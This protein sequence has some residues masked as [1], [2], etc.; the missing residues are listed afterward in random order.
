MEEEKLLLT[1]VTTVPQECCLCIFTLLSC[2][3]SSLP[4]NSVLLIGLLGLKEGTKAV[5]AALPNYNVGS[6]CLV[7]QE[8]L[9]LAPRYYFSEGP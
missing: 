2:P 5:L 6:R 8:G 3:P 7:P 9:H 4:L 1:I